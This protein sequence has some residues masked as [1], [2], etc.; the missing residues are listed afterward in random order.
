[1]EDSLSGKAR[2]NTVGAWISDPIITDILLLALPEFAKRGFS[3]SVGDC[4]KY[5]AIVLSDRVC[6]NTTCKQ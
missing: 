2:K 3:K 4:D 6:T 1:M 5:Q